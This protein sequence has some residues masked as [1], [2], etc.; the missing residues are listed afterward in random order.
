MGEVIHDRDI[1][2]RESAVIINNACLIVYRIFITQCPF[3]TLKR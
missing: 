2:M 3:G 1:Y